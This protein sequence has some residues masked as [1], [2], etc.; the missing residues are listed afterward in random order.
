M[1]PALPT[2]MQS[3]SSSPVELLVDL[4]GGRLLAF[5]AELVDRVDEHDR[6]RVGRA[7]ARASSAWSKLP[8]SE[9]TRA[10]CISVW[11]SLPCAILPSGTITA[12]VM[13]G[14][15]GVGGGAGGGVAGRGA[16]HR[17]G[18][19][20]HGRRD[21]A[22]HAAV[23]ERAGRVGALE[24]QAHLG[25][26]HLREHRRA[27]QRRRALLQ[28]SRAG[29]RLR[30]AGARGSARSA[31]RACRSA[32]S[33]AAGARAAL[34]RTPLRSRG[35]CAAPSARSR[36]SPIRVD[37][38]A[39]ARLEHRVGDH[40]QPRVLAHAPL[41]DRLDRH[42]VLAEHLRRPPRARRAVG[43]VQVQV[44]GALDV[45]DERQRRAAAPA[46][47]APPVITLTTSPST[48]L[49]VWRPPA[50]GPDIV[51]SVIASDS[52]VTALNGP[53]DRGER[54]A[55]RRGTSGARAP[56]ARRRGA[57]RCR[58]ASAPRPSSRAYSRS[59][60]CRCS[61]PS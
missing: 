4:E 61:I 54:M 24:L 58:S 57:R 25:A 41:H 11:A 52:T 39:Q 16:D 32:P 31:A 26:D 53:D 13:P 50:P 33:T 46:A 47:A 8:C 23:L 27:Q 30:T 29:R 19:F 48:A 9:I 60:P 38:G 17:L 42:P 18:A 35:S 59:S 37:G 14:A 44:E 34:I 43:D 28:A 45:L 21:R 20:A 15:R 6:V 1:L 7:R 22:G 10:P 12:Q 40:H 3:A 36:S 2:G 49:A 51:I 55:R 56:R 5:D